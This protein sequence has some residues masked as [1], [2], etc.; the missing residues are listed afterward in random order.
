MQTTPTPNTL[1]PQL[2]EKWL[3]LIHQATETKLITYRERMMYL[4]L[5]L[6]IEKHLPP[7]P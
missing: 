1:T 5:Y 6:Q 2:M 3:H 7:N 4:Y